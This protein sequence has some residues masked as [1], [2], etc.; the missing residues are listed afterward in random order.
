MGTASHIFQCKP[1]LSKL[2]GSF[3]VTWSK[4]RR[5]FFSE[6]RKSR[7]ILLLSRRAIIFMDNR[8]LPICLQPRHVMTVLPFN[9]W[10]FHQRQR[11]KSDKR[12]NWEEEISINVGKTC[13]FHFYLPLSFNA[14]LSLSLPQQM[15]FCIVKWCRILSWVKVESQKWLRNLI[16]L[17]CFVMKN[18]QSIG[19]VNREFIALLF[20]WRT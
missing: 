3:C 13:H 10:I 17:L 14:S 4:G 1:S 16:I 7:T 9:K 8:L 6:S 15:I 18:K 2:I 19:G 12:I 5:P 11:G 20:D